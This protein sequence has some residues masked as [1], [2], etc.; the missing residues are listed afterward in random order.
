GL[1]FPGCRELSE[2]I[3]RYFEGAQSKMF[4]EAEEIDVSGHNLVVFHVS[5]SVNDES[6][7]HTA[8]V[9]MALSLTT[10]LEAVKRNKVAGERWS[11]VIYDE[12]QRILK[13]KKANASINDLATTIRKWNG[14]VGLATN[15]PGALLSQSSSGKAA[16]ASGLWSN[17]A[18]K[19]LFWL[20]QKDMK[21]VAENAELPDEVLNRLKGLHK[22][23]SFIFRYMDKN[24]Y[25]VLRLE[26]PDEEKRLVKTRKLNTA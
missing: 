5:N 11:A 1:D 8:A 7:Q 4:S 26:L 25:D 9:K 20:E 22:T 24:A 19:V 14:L 3:W 2:K 23:K 15:D 17:S 12:G 13:D 10:V 21:I 18:F 16:D 6:E